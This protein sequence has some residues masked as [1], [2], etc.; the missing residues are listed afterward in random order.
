L[1]RPES[2][3]RTFAILAKPDHLH[4]LADGLTA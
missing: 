1:L 2:S 4:F 3:N